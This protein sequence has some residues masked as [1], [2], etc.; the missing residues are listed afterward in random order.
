MG[1]T[2]L[3]VCRLLP[4]QLLQGFSRVEAE[5]VD[6]VERLQARDVSV[7]LTM[8]VDVNTDTLDFEVDSDEVL[9]VEDGSFKLLVIEA[10]LEDDRSTTSVVTSV[11]IFK[12]TGGPTTTEEPMRCLSV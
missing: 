1:M 7:A 5:V 6:V 11:A 10:A 8:L 12:A 9:E 2:R 4:W 3:T